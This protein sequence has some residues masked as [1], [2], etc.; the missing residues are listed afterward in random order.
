MPL[1]QE[2]TAFRP[3]EY[4]WAYKFWQKQNQ[5]HWLPEEVPL[6]DDVKDF[7][8]KLTDAERS[9]IINV[10]R[11]FTQMDITVADCYQRKYMQVFKP[12]EIQMMLA[13]FANMESIHIAAYSHLL[14]TLGLPESE[15]H[16]FVNY[17]EMKDKIDYLKGFET[18]DPTQV[19]VALAAV[20]AFGEGLSLFASFAMLLNFPRF[21]KMKG[22]GDIVA[23]S[24]K[25]E[26]LHCQ[27]MSHIFKAWCKENKGL[28]DKQQLS[29]SITEIM[30]KT[31]ELE[32]AF[33][34]RAFEMGPIEGLTA[35]D[36]KKYIR[37]IADIRLKQLGF[38]KHFGIRKN[39]LQWMTLMLNGAEFGN[40]FETRVTEY[41][42]AAM[43]GEWHEAYDDL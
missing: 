36:V 18:G 41:S 6:S 35:D 34:D 13:S 9:L 24:M 14:E 1:T 20:S 32:D 22:M 2:R 10:F 30:L 8:N 21:N 19:A 40:F 23:F 33:I 43:E 39:P 26:D 3:L 38:S 11:L 12:V 42:K 28:I 31:I 15:Y 5:M 29:E 17:K 37:Y 4:E 25:D 27:G 16:E 7:K